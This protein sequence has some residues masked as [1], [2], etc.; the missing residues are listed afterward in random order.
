MELADYRRRRVPRH[1]FNRSA[2]RLME[3]QRTAEPQPSTPRQAD[4]CN[5]IS[6]HHSATFSAQTDDG[7]ADPIAERQLKKTY[8]G[9]AERLAGR[10]HAN[11]SRMEQELAIKLQ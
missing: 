6:V 9:S 5:H 1:C 2:L 7:Q 4:R 8:A 3:S 11:P 10:L